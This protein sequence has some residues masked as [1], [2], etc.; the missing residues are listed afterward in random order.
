MSDAE[1]LNADAHDLDDGTT[2]NSKADETT[3]S[4]PAASDAPTDLELFEKYIEEDLDFDL[5][6]RG[7]LREGMI[8][9]VR[10]S[11]ASDQRG[12]Q[13]RRRSSAVG[14]GAP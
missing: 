14:L 2:Q 6:G 12:Q 1:Q 8:V 5:P 13:A 10:P 7:D 11:E 3:A 4:E 9:E